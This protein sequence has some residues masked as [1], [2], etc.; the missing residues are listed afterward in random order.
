M[1]EFTSTFSG[2]LNSA[3]C[4]FDSGGPS[5]DPNKLII[6]V[7]DIQEEN[8]QEEEDH[9]EYALFGTNIRRLIQLLRSVRG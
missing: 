1:P 7:E 4:V 8:L 9:N 6:R 3:P 5:H 2:P